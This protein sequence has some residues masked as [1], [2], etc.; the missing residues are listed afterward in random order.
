MSQTR[1]V[2]PSGNA[3]IDRQHAR[4]NQLIH[5]A[6]EAARDGGTGDA[7][8]LSL[9]EFRSALAHHF[10]MERLIISGAGFD[11][12]VR[13][14]QIHGTILGQLDAALASVGDLTTVAR[15]HQV[16]DHFEQVLLEHEM[17]EDAV[18][19]DF[20]RA[21]GGNPPLKWREMMALGI[22]WIDAQHRH[23]VELFNELSRAAAAEVHDECDRLLDGFHSFAQRHFR[24]EEEHLERRRGRPPAEHHREHARLGRHLEGL[25]AGGFSPAVLVQHYL[26]FWMID[27]I[28]GIDRADLTTG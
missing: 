13:H 28:L 5:Q 14:D 25:R 15:R 4:L 22:D 3:V 9:Q 19:W 10:D 27:H 24:E 18:F 17:V 21:H 2:P 16:L 8:A 6:V 12:V 7:F 23:M 20:V 1:R 26:R 11:G